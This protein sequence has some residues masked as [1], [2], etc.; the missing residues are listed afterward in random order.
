MATKT[1][2]IKLTSQDMETVYDTLTKFIE[3]DMYVVGRD[4]FTAVP[5]VYIDGKM[6]ALDTRFIF[7]QEEVPSKDVIKR[8]LL[9]MTSRNC[10]LGATKKHQC[11]VCQKDAPTK[12]NSC[13]VEYYCSVECQT[14]DYVSHR[15]G[16]QVIMARRLNRCCRVKCDKEM[17]GVGIPCEDCHAVRYCSRRCHQ[18]DKSHKKS[19]YCDLSKRESENP[20]TRQLIEGMIG[21]KLDQLPKNPQALKKM[22]NPKDFARW[23]ELY[24]TY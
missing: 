24:F 11:G 23:S 8:E 7:N 1:K 3:A 9:Y 10:R 2:I 21:M 17:T 5:N 18:K 22:H 19:G 6:A 16:C 15:A 13:R 4:Q 14:T 12:C 20:K